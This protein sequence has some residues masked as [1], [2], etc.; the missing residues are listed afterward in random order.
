MLDVAASLYPLDELYMGAGAL[1]LSGGSLVV[2]VLARQR[3]AALL[4][5]GCIFALGGIGSIAGSLL[6]PLCERRLTVGQ[7]ILV[8]RWMS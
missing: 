8:C 7:S 4:L 6:A 1:S 5:I 2:I 3:G